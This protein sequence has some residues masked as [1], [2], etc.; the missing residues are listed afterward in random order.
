MGGQVSSLISCAQAAGTGTHQPGGYVQ[1]ENGDGSEIS[2]RH[3]GSRRWTEG[4]HTHPSGHL[5]RGAG[6]K[7]SG[8]GPSSVWGD[9]VL[10]TRHLAQGEAR[11]PAGMRE[12]IN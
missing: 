10:A 11:V 8:S 6:R 3:L 7:Q 9:R 4:R 12:N 5:I 1:R 2:R